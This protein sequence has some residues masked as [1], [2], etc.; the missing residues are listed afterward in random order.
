MGLQH[1]RRVA[2]RIKVTDTRCQFVG[3]LL[4]AL[5]LRC[6]S[7]KFRESRGRYCGI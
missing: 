7:S 1:L 4:I 3:A 6:A 5:S 2:Q